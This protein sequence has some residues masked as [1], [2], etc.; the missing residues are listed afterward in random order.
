[1]KKVLS[2]LIAVLMIAALCACSS[3][4]A[5]E[6]SIC[7]RNEVGAGMDGFYISSVNSE[8]WGDKLNYARVSDGNSIYID[9]DKLTDGSGALYDIGTID[10]NGMA[11]DVYEVPISIGDTIAISVD[12]DT[13]IATITS[14]DGVSTVYTGD[15][16]QEIE[17]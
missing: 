7:F 8:E 14:A 3:E 6:D 11:Y 5:K 2:I 4:S 9:A 16:Y 12:G 10:E 17:P 1:M 13:A 15:A